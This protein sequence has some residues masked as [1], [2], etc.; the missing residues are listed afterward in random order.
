M[1]TGLKTIQTSKKLHQNDIKELSIQISLSGLSFC[2]LNRSKN[3]IGHIQHVPFDKKLTPFDILERIIATLDE[4]AVYDQAFSEVLLIYQNELSCLVPKPLFDEAHCADYLKF[5]A[6]ILTTDY[7]SFD[8]I[9][10]N[11]S[12]NVYVPLV[13]VNNFMFDRFGSF[14]YKH[15]STILI[16][17]ILKHQPLSN[18]PNI[19]VNVNEHSFEIVV[20]KDYNLVLY[21]TFE[22][23]TKE[24]FI[25]YILFTIEQLKMDPETLKLKLMGTIAEGDDLYQIVYTFIRNVEFVM[26]HHKFNFIEEPSVAH[27]DYVLLNSFK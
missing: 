21:N 3:T 19:Y 17:H 11:D 1:E 20:V 9:H 24:D 5:N 6:K 25:Y 7:I 10:F 23:I 2:I 12:V 15:S 4:G 13:N 16:E 14:E 27:N 26:P 18:V 8:D 22:Y